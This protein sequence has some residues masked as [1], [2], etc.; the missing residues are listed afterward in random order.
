LYV[1]GGREW[2]KLP[3]AVPGFDLQRGVVREDVAQ[4]QEG[5]SKGHAVVFEGRIHVCGGKTEGSRESHYRNKYQRFMRV[6]RYDPMNN[7]WEFL[8]SLRVNVG[9]LQYGVVLC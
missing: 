1:C 8:D 7:K 5:G 3:E 6:K 2:E 9:N 4:L